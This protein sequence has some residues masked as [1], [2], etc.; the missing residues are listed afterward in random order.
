MTAV[1]RAM[2]TGCGICKTPT[3]RSLSPFLRMAAMAGSTCGSTSMA[4]VR[5][6]RNH[7]GAFQISAWAGNQACACNNVNMA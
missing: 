1:H 6:D 4:K 7:V 3:S 2:A 5:A